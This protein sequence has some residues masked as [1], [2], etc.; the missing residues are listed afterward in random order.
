M[1]ALRLLKC[2]G[3]SVR[4]KRPSYRIA[5]YS[6]FSLWLHTWLSQG[7]RAKHHFGQSRG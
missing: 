1:S 5:N 3:F 7:K 6:A 4:F 2:S